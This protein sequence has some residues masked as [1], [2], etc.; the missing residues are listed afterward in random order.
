MGRLSIIDLP[1]PRD[2]FRID[3][4]D[5]RFETVD[6]ARDEDRKR[7]ALIRASA[8]RTL[9][10]TSAGRTNGLAARLRYCNHVAPATMA[11]SLYMRDQRIRV[12]GALLKLI[13]ERN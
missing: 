2:D 3:K 10:V 13:G 1:W 9:D 6:K 5:R 4:R 12:I 11:S 8:A 7:V